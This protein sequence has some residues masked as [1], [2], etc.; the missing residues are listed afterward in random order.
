MSTSGWGGSNLFGR[1]FVNTSPLVFLARVGL[2]MM[3]REGATEVVVP[4]PVLLE[5]QAHGPDDPTMKAIGC[6]YWVVVTQLSVFCRRAVGLPAS[7]GR[8]RRRSTRRSG[9]WLVGPASPARQTAASASPSAPCD[10]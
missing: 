10:P 3:L 7:R 2:L 1:R 4:E 6:N 8:A 5:I 9:R